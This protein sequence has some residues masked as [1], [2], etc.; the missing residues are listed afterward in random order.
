MPRRASPI[1]RFLLECMALAVALVL[2]QA[3][4]P[5]PLG[6]SDDEVAAAD[7]R[8]EAGHATVFRSRSRSRVA[9]VSPARRLPPFATLAWSDS[10]WLPPVSPERA[11]RGEASER[12]AVLRVH[13][14]VPRMSSDEPPRG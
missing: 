13:R 14:H 9:P 8:V 7:Q 2:V 11:L 10:E 12:D 4:L 3:P 6:G 1:L 5:S